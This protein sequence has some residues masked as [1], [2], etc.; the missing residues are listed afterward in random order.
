[1]LMAQ[2]D[3]DQV[4]GPED[5]NF[6]PHSDDWWETET[7]WFSFNVPER[8]M[9]GWF[10]GYIR[11]NMN[12]SGGGFFVWDASATT[13]WELPYYK[14]SFAQ[15]LPPQRDLRDFAFPENYRIKML[16]P[17]DQYHLS[18]QDRKLVAID[19]EHHAIMPPHPFR[20][21]APPFDKSPHFDQSGRI[22]GEM[23]LHGERIKID[24]FS[25]R[26]RSWGPRIDHRSGRI[27]Y[28][29]AT[30]D[31]KNGFCLFSR[32]AQVGADGLEPVN[33]GYLLADGRKS[34]ILKGWR[35][36]ERDPRR[37]WV[38]RVEVEAEDQDG[39]KLLADGRAVSRM[40]LPTARGISCYTLLSWT[41]NGAQA[42]GEDQ[43]VWRNDQW[44]AAMRKA[45][46]EA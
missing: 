14:Y 33:H 4:F 23:T 24:C 20:H 41:L 44:S 8:A 46:T 15:P 25:V 31:A 35:R 30:A 6:H 19:I 37:N 5:D 13:T 40:M 26:D 27:G 43:D 16:K 28:S 36:L 17:L 2:L 39:R 29:F 34:Q 3:T 1:M 11:P 45:R 22:V 7:C 42:W 32:S 12:L 21:G 38:T 10:Y 18:Y 9:G